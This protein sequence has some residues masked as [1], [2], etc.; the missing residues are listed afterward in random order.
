M[1]PFDDPEF[2]NPDQRLPLCLNRRRTIPPASHFQRRR[3]WPWLGC[4]ELRCLTLK[5][6]YDEGTAVAGTGAMCYMMSKQQYF[7]HK[8]GNAGSPSDVVVPKTD[9]M[10][11]GAEASDSPVDVHQYSPQ[12]I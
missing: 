10:I 5:A 2:L 8:V 1:A 9:D 6:A 12:P 11:W 7:G 3:S 4:P